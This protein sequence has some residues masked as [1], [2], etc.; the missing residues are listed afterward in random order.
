VIGAQRLRVSTLRAPVEARLHSLPREAVL[1]AAERLRV[2]TLEVELPGGDGGDRR[3]FGGSEEGPAAT[4]AVG[5][6]AFFARLLTRGEIG[7]G[8]AYV[9]GLWSTTD[10]VALLELGARNRAALDLDRGW[11]RTPARLLARWR[12]RRRRNTEAGSRE[13]I[14]AHYDL[15]NE[16]YRLFLDETLAYSSAIFE[17]E[18]QPLADAQRAKYE[19]IAA[20]AGL[21]PGSRVLEIGCG[22][23]GFALHAAQRHGCSVT[24]LTISEEQAALARERVAA[25]GLA[26]L[27]EVR[28]LD[29]RRARGSYDAVVSIEMLEAVGAEYYRGFFEVVERALVPGGRAAIQT[30]AVPDRAFA[31]QRDG[32][33][34]IQTYIFPGGLLPSLAEIERTLDGTSLLLTGVRDIG[35]HYATTLAQWRARF[36]EHA[37]EVRALGFDE[38]FQ[39]MWEYYLALS[40]AGFRT[41]HTQD[42]QIVLEKPAA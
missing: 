15:S 27:V 33:N 16:L 8:E 42:L 40:E 34:W 10:L 5:D 36:L 2:G 37:E 25:A 18:G 28:L 19:R 9:D 29:Y 35:P 13:N 26:D 17:Y 7:F 32:A 30:I 23:G 1:R 41:R 24:A 39:R 3:L 6:D 11:A 38:R 14:H 4:I 20:D 12:H 31:A 22:W 21:R